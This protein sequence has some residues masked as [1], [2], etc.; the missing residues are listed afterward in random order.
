MEITR[1]HVQTLLHTRDESFRKGVPASGLLYN[2][3]GKYLTQIVREGEDFCGTE[4]LRQNNGV[5]A[6]RTYPKDVTSTEL[7]ALLTCSFDQRKAVDAVL[8]GKTAF[9]RV[10]FTPRAD[11]SCTEAARDIAKIG[12][13]DGCITKVNTILKG[14]G[15]VQQS[16][17]KVLEDPLLV[18]A[19]DYFRRSGC[20]V[21]W[22][23]EQVYGKTLNYVPETFPRDVATP[24][25]IVRKC[26]SRM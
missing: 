18:S 26:S 17:Y 11:R 16:P 3:E 25:Q 7:A 19:L 6:W 22:V 15:R 13:L 4:L 14:I 5:V 12:V 21:D 2:S 9:W 24:E 8:L 10:M 1:E 20:D 23:K